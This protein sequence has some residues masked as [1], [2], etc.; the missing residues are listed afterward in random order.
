MTSTSALGITQHHAAVR[1]RPQHRRR[2][3]GR[4]GGDRR[5]PRQLPPRHADAAVVPEG[6][7]GRPADPLPRAQLADAAALDASTSTPRRCIAQRISMVD[8]VAQVQVFGA[9]KY[10][11]RVQLDPDAARRARHRHRRGRQRARERATSTCR[12]ARSTARTR[13]FTVQAN[14]QL[15]NA[16]E[17]RPLIV[18]YRNGAPGAARASSGSVDRQRRERQGRRAGSTA[19]RARS[20]SRSSASPAPTPSRSS[21]RIKAAAAARSATQMPP[22]VNLDIL[23]DRSRVD[24]R[25]GRT[26]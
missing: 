23:Y 12:P 15:M 25:V 16:A 21:T 13:R 18:A 9:Q 1:A 2:R 26:T 3:A 7:P 4:A 20:C 11:V 17:Y 24:P 22:S 10:A 5:P 19:T 14:G 8:G 6:E